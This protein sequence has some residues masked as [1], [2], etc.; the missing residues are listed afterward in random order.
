MT[1]LANIARLVRSVHH[2]PAA[3]LLHRG[4]LQVK[5]RTLAAVGG[6][7][8][9]VVG[10][11]PA[12]SPT[13]SRTLPGAGIPDVHSA[14]HSQGDTFV[15]DF[16]N[17]ARRYQL[18]LDWHAA[19][20]NTGTRLWK[21]H[22]H[23]FDWSKDLSDAHFRAITE[24]WI[25][26]NRPY[27]THYWMDSWNSY[28]ISIRLVAW[29][30]EYSQRR[31]RLDS[32]FLE[33]LR[34]SIHEQIEFLSAN[35]ESDIGGNHIIKNIR[36]LY[37]G[38]RFFSGAPA[39]RYGSLAERLLARELP[40]QIL[41]DGF[42]FELSPSYHCQVFGD[43]MD[44]WRLMP[45][46]SLR[47]ELTRKLEAMAQ[48]VADLTHP[49]GRVA[50]F[51]DAGLSMAATPENLLAAYEGLSGR[52]P[53]VHGQAAY[54]A[55]GYYVL[56]GEDFY[57][58]YD[59]GRVGPDGLPAHAHGDIFSFELSVRGQRMIV[60]SGVF[61]YSAGARRT[62]ARST[63]A[64]N[65]LSLDDRDQCEFWASFRLGHRANVRV[66][67]AQLDARR[68]HIDAQHDGYARLPGAPIHQRIMRMDRHGRL[69]VTDIV[70]GGAGQRAMSRLLLHPSV[71]IAECQDCILLLRS[72][73]ARLALEAPLAAVTVIPAVWWPDLGREIATRQ[74][75]LDYGTAPGEWQYS[76]TV[77]RD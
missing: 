69:A 6:V 31:D 75:V 25:A 35:I 55:A 59:A 5:R 70:K 30:G 40:K 3:Q 47:R 64:H 43:L 51:N 57:L 16:L 52:S 77:M 42:H 60:D 36:A 63:L 33:L 44:C 4:R 46:S 14:V 17:V 9:K 28:A 1:T 67:T 66:N 13:V 62:H 50:L 26:Q 71:E 24:D 53:A 23:Y 41:C 73:Q 15:F 37:W 76:L 74:I 32:S 8:P 48:A 18:P 22:L 19:E 38:S 10:R 21:L 7:M 29:M 27:R 72:A 58:A 45:D 11:R 49:D 54:P 68:L 12:S 56:R 39:E 65:T 2:T 61:E 34:A 20:L